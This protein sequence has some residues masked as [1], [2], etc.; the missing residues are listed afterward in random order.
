MHDQAI[1]FVR[2]QVQL[3]GYDT[4]EVRVLDI[5]GRKTS[6]SQFYRG[7]QPYELFA[8]TYEYLVM[9]VTPGPDVDIVGDATDVPGLFKA[10]PDLENGFDVVVCTEV[11]EHVERWHKIL[12]SCF[13]A[14][15]DG[16]RLILTCAGPGR[17]P[18]PATTED[19]D[20]PPGEWY[21]NV[22][23]LDVRETLRL[24]GYRDIMTCQVGHDTQAVAT[25]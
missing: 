8:A 15:K 9:D 21:Q 1:D 23:H 4:A 2:R 18:H 22:P 14:L 19:W 10:H 24:I 25:K 13:V 6:T 11:L 20:P 16:G 7:P 12:E 17:R 5:G 3:Y